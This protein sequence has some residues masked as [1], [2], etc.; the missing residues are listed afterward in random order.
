MCELVPFFNIY[1]VLCVHMCRLVHM[2]A[3]AVEARRGHRLFWI[4]AGMRHMTLCW[5]ASVIPPPEQ[6]APLTS[7]PSICPAP[8]TAV[9]MS[10]DVRKLITASKYKKGGGHI[11]N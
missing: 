1:F 2:S 9:F 3:G 11:P 4:Q 5:E 6:Q 10:Y 7:A 8:G